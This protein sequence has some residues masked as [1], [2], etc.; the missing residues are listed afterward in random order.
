MITISKDMNRIRLNLTGLP[1]PYPEVLTVLKAKEI[2][3][4]DLLEVMIDSPPSIEII[5]DE[6]QDLELTI[7]S[8]VE[9]NR[10]VWK[11][12]IEKQQ[13]WGH[14]RKI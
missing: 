1:C 14:E 3:S 7:R 10:N 5:R 9:I 11:I 2:T 4:T 6:L 12:E 13:V 8:I